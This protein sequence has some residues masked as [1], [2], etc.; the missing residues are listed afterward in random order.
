MRRPCCGV[1]EF[2]LFRKRIGVQPVEQF[3][4]I[5]RD[6]LHLREMRMRVDEARQHQMRPVVDRCRPVARLPLDSRIDAGRND[7]AVA[8]QQAAV[9]LVALGG[10]VVGAFGPAQ[11]G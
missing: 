7:P 2:R 5:G 10:I 1:G 9:F 8:D 11:E 3:G 6:D 4:A